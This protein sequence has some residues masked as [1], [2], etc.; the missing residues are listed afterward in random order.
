MRTTSTAAAAAAKTRDDDAADRVAAI[1]RL[2]NGS[3]F[4]CPRPLRVRG[5]YQEDAHVVLT[6]DLMSVT[7]YGALTLGL[8]EADDPAEDEVT[9]EVEDHYRPD[10]AA[11]TAAL[12][13]R[14]GD[15][16]TWLLSQVERQHRTMTTSCQRSSP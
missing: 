6:D 3:I 11:A 9:V 14:L 15:D 1:R 16:L 12:L 4:G 10:R 13:V 7:E 5:A 2:L 8:P